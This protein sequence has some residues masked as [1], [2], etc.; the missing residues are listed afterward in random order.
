MTTLDNARYTAAHCARVHAERPGAS[1]S[2]EVWLVTCEWHMPRAEKYFRVAGLAVVPAP[3]RVPPGRLP[4]AFTGR[5]HA[6][7]ER[8]AAWLDEVAR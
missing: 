1:G 2:L 7:R 6:L 8:A 5:L 3:A 4:P